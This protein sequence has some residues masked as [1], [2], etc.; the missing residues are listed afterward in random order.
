MSQTRG[1]LL[2]I[3]SP[4]TAF[5]LSAFRPFMPP[6]IIDILLIAIVAGY[7]LAV[8]VISLLGLHRLWHVGLA[9][10]RRRGEPPDPA[11]DEPLP[12]VT[13]QLPMYDEPAVAERVITAARLLDYPSDRFEIQVLDDS[14]EPAASVMR[15]IVAASAGGGPDVALIQRADRTGFKAGALAHGLQ[16]AR[17]ELIAIFDAD[18]QP[19]PSFLRA[20]V[21]HFEDPA[22]GLVQTRWTY[23]NR[24]AGVLTELQ[25][26]LLDAHF[27]IEQLARSR[28]WFTFNG[29]AGIWRRTAIGDAGGWSHDTLTE[30]ADLSYRAQMAGWRF[31]YRPD[32]ECSSELPTSMSDVTS[33]QHR[34]NKG[35]MQT[36]RKLAWPIMRSDAPLL[37]K[38]D[39]LLH[40]LSPLVAMAI[41]LLALLALPALAVV[42]FID[43]P[44]AG[45]APAVAL[46]S[47]LLG[48]LTAS[49]F[50]LVARLIAGEGSRLRA[51]G[52]TILLLA[53]AFALG[54]GLS[55]VN[56]RA[57]AEALLGHSS[58]F[59][60]TRKTG[61][62]GTAVRDPG[63]L[64][65]TLLPSGWIE[66]LM[67]ALMFPAIM[68]AVGTTFTIVGAPFLFMFAT[69]FLAVGAGR[70]RESLWAGRATT[71]ESSC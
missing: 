36:A 19:P 44:L 65:K 69:G 14:P 5:R 24:D 26:L 15:R 18:F 20:T 45:I 3:R 13:V 6:I 70:L 43:R 28:R 16:S 46:V 37:T 71:A 57:A 32:I 50:F 54:V 29:T 8:G 58:P 56:S 52:S 27:H 40:L 7:A 1:C 21:P 60:R 34:W 61:D 4:D 49:L 23:S 39:A 35:L 59:V 55:V 9:L 38:L 47:L 67:A 31:I 2:L 68:I 42:T 10:L 51:V 30:D 64:R 63:L 17:G 66:L 12:F 48:T 33:Q 11:G 41:L 53:P 25:A 62:G 22:V